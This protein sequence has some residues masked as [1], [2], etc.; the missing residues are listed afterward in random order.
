MTPLELPRRW[1]ATE[2]AGRTRRT[3]A[4]DPSTARAFGA[5]EWSATL[6]ALLAAALWLSAMAW[7]ERPMTTTVLV[8]PAFFGAGTLLA[9]RSAIALERPEL[10][11]VFATGLS[12]RAVG[13]WYRYKEAADALEYHQE[14]IRIAAAFRRFDL[15]VPSN[16]PVPGTG[17][18]R[19]ASGLVHAVSYDDLLV[20]FAVF[21]LAAFAGCLLFVQ[22]WHVA[23]PDDEVRRYA[24]LLMVWPALVFWPS[25]L[26]KEAWMLFGLG[27]ASLG[28]AHLLAHRAAR[29]VPLLV[30]GLVWV[31]FVRPHVGLLVAGALAVAA[32]LRSAAVQRGRLA[33]RVLTAV[34]ALVG[35]AMLA[36]ATA[37]RFAVDRLGAD[38]VAETLDQTAE[39]TTTG[40]AT[41]V[42]ARVESPLDYPAAVIT[43]LFRPFPGEAGGLDGLGSSLEAVT[44]AA[45]LGL[46]W[47][48]VLHA[49]RRLRSDPYLLYATS[50]I[51]S[52]C[53]AFAV[54][55]NFG[56]LVRQ[57]TQVLPLL[58]LLVGL[59]PAAH[60]SV[61]R[62][63]RPTTPWASLNA[64]R[65][66]SAPTS[67]RPPTTPM[68][69]R[70]RAR[71][72]P[73]S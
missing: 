63:T 53:Y 20:S 69:D 6:L 64:R 52:F 7:V 23:L 45:V 33:A 29:G 62:H 15:T 73:G 4:E 47:R 48:R 57:R 40:S 68:P 5:W 22:A 55:G 26:G 37:E 49:V 31:G 16:R 12:L 71:Q 66:S 41:F 27:L 21:T 65:R 39:S 36:D 24:T 70:P 44:L 60:A 28:V 8:L 10:L 46:G 2:R 13:L 9:R 43:V 14:G 35:G 58:F 61:S 42:S 50:F 30:V 38:Q 59:A 67:R 11:G 56:I 18:L 34:V 3:A 1:E 72:L 25:S 17:T 32:L 51:A 54:I 19:L